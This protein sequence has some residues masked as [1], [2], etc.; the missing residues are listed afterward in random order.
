MTR[1]N[2]KNLENDLRRTFNRE[3]GGVGF[4]IAEQAGRCALGFDRCNNG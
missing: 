1:W 4:W 2:K 3:M